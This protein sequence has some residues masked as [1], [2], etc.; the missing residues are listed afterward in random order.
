MKSENEC[1]HSLYDTENDSALGCVEEIESVSGHLFS[2]DPIEARVAVRESQRTNNISEAIV[3]PET[4]DKLTPAATLEQTTESND[5]KGD[6]CSNAV[7]SGDC[8]TR[9][10]LPRRPL[11]DRIMTSRLASASTRCSETRDSPSEIFPSLASQIDR[12]I[13]VDICDSD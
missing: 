10:S 7:T 6:S 2:S 4:P 13:V 1:T 11:L 5:A 9:V 8:S 3:E 12:T